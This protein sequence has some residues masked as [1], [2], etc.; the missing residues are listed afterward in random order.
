MREETIIYKTPVA[1]KA[2]NGNVITNI[3][4]NI[5]AGEGVITVNDASKLPVRSY[6]T[7]DDETLYIK[8]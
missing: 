2:Y 7:I 1:T 3:S 5:L 8:K 6:I 4:D